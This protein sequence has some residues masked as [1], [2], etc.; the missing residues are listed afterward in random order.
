MSIPV[1]QKSKVLLVTSTTIVTRELMDSSEESS[2]INWL[3]VVPA[4]LFLY[5]CVYN[6]VFYTTG[7]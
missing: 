3:Y 1:G 6:Q 7:Q 5:I 4:K 2:P